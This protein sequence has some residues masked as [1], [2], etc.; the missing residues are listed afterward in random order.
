MEQMRSCPLRGVR[1]RPDADREYFCSGGV[2][3]SSLGAT[4][5][6]CRQCRVPDLELQPLAQCPNCDIYTS[7]RF[8]KETHSLVVDYDLQCFAGPRDSRCTRCPDGAVAPLTSSMP[9]TGER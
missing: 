1:A 7:A 9:E 6:L 2:N 5:A 8:A 4:A 3:F